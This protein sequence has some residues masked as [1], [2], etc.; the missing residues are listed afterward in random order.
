MIGPGYSRYWQVERCV[1]FKVICPV[2][3]IDES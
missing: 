2:R 3:L 1:R